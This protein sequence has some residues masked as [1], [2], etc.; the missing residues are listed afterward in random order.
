[1]SKDS[2]ENL[3]PEQKRQLLAK[4]LQEK[5]NQPQHFPLSFAQKRLWFLDKLQPESSAYNNFYI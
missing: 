3:T 2:L 4:L 5:A 1:M